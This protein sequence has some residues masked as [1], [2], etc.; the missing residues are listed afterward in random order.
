M[1]EG[2]PWETDGGE[3]AVGNG[4]RASMRE[5]GKSFCKTGQRRGRMPFCQ[6]YPRARSVYSAGCPAC[7]ERR[8]SL[9][10]RPTHLALS[11]SADTAPL[12]ASEFPLSS[13]RVCGF[14]AHTSVRCIRRTDGRCRYLSFLI[15][16]RRDKRVSAH[17]LCL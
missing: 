13:A 12:P 9:A 11:P 1:L 10:H 6:L 7:Q 14:S 17:F 8:L 16:Q 15:D 4:E 3:C 2:W 5:K